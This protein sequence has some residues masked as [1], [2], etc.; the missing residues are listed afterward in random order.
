MEL[1][2]RSALRPS[3]HHSAIRSSVLVSPPTTCQQYSFE[4]ME[5]FWEHRDRAN[6]MDSNEL[7]TTLSI[8]VW[9]REIRAGNT[10]GYQRRPQSRFA[11]DAESTG[12]ARLA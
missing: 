2:L 11:R 6:K 8:H 1:G 12:G 4:S 5:N 10:P 3:E 7:R 9:L